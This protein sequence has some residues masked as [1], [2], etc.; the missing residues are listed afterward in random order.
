MLRTA[1]GFTAVNYSILAQLPADR[2][3]HLLPGIIDDR[4]TDLVASRQDPFTCRPH[5]LGYFG[6]L[7]QEKGVD[8]LLNAVPHLPDDWRLQVGGTGPLAHDL[9]KMAR[10]DPGRV[11]FL[12]NLTGDA[13]YDAL[14]S[15]DATVVPPEQLGG[16]GL[17]VFPFKVLEYLVADTHIITTPLPD[18]GAVDLRFTYRWDGTV[19]GLVRE[20]EKAA[21]SFELER[22][23]RTNAIHQAS[24]RFTITGAAALFAELLRVAEQTSSWPP[25]GSEASG[26]AAARLGSSLHP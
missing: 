13:L 21:A 22:E 8:V 12:G 23:A 3:R 15:C 16:D 14:C 6:G 9:Q 19:T 2:P 17:G 10:A 24:A 4:L 26:A 5:V 11:T 7:S 18:I 25:A 20:L 1:S